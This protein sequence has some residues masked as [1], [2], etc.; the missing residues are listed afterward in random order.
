[1]M[2]EWPCAGGLIRQAEMCLAYHG[3]DRMV[4]YQARWRA[5]G[6]R[7]GTRDLVTIRGV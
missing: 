3:L 4:D 7:P 1:M 2:S 5:Q 6:A